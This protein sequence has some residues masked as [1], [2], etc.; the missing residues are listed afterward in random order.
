MS[1]TEIARSTGVAVSDSAHTEGKRAGFE[2][3]YPSKTALA[4]KL[5]AFY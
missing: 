3:A 5:L 1:T 2:T 4:V